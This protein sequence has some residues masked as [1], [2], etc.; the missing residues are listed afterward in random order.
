VVYLYYFY[1]SFSC[2]SLVFLAN[3][4]IFST[5][6]LLRSGTISIFM[7]IMEEN[8]EYVV[9]RLTHKEYAN[10]HSDIDST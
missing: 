3:F 5:P 1:L 8:K 4:L 9:V 7:E 6:G 10:Y 2:K